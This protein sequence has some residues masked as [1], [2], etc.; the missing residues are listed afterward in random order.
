MIT[1]LTEVATWGFAPFMSERVEFDG[2]D[3]N[4]INL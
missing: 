4:Y 3:S 2:F 1:V